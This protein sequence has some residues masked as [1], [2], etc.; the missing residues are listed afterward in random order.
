FGFAAG[1]KL[2]CAM[3]VELI[4]DPAWDE[5]AFS[6][7]VLPKAPKSIIKALASSHEWPEGGTRD[8]QSAKGKG[9]VILL[10][11]AP[12]TGKTMTAESG[13]LNNPISTKMNKLTRSFR[14]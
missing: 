6:K 4:S 1:I 3:N 13:T 5:N 7:L 14:I 10:H 11:G 2:W 9:L 8:A 12:G